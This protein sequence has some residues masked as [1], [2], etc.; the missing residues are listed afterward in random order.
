MIVS[1]LNLL[2]T[3]GMFTEKITRHTTGAQEYKIELFQSIYNY[4]EQFSRSAL[5]QLSWSILD[6][7]G[8]SRFILDYLGLSRTI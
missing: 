6:Y 2:L 8:A 5:S 7:L 4:I 3:L 1:F